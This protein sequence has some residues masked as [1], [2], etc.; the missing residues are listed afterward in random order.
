MIECLSYYRSRKLDPGYQGPYEEKYCRVFEQMMGNTGHADAVAT[1]TAAVYVAL[2]A[3]ALPKGSEVLVSP[4]CDPGTYSA[5]VLNGLR[6]KL[7]DSMP[8]SWNIG[9]EEVAARIN[10]RSKAVVVV[11]LA[12]MAAPIGPIA[13][14]AHQKG[15][16]VIE[17][18]SQA[19][20]AKWEGQCVGSF[21]DIAAFSTMY[22]KAHITGACGGVVFS[23]HR[24]L[25][26]LAT[27]HADR[28]KP[29]WKPDFD[30]RDPSQFL[31]PALNF[32]TDE[33]SCAIGLA[34][35]QR[36]ASSI[37]ARR[38]FVQG[39]KDGLS[40]SRL[41]MPFPIGRDDSPFIYPIQIR[42][43]LSSWDKQRI[44]RAILAEG[45]PLN[46]HYKYLA[47]DWPWLQRHLVDDYDPPQARQIR[48]RCFCLYLNEQYG[49]AEVK[50]SLAAFRKVEKACL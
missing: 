13:A 42:S 28:G 22:R 25:Y 46:P 8:G 48:D 12:G 16:K 38:L 5:I 9:P 45:I 14:M 3:L 36:L 2:A 29:R 20:G 30:D 27:A 39:I 35:L 34:S 31:F 11:H 37:K 24:E 15:I 23:K 41:F 26:Q 49:I 44:T 19:H 40:V 10:G 33:I 21:G 47:R 43:G 17:D 6:P 32:H 4:I 1:G 7:I 18:C 50:D